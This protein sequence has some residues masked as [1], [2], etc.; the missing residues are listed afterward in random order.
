MSEGWGLY[1][2]MKWVSSTLLMTQENQD[3]ANTQQEKGE[4]AGATGQPT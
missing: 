4:Q 3:V 2:S 1:E